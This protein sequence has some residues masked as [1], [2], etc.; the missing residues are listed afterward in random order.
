MANKKPL[1]DLEVEEEIARLKASPLVA[2]GKTE[3]RIR[4]RRRQYMYCLRQYEKKGAELAASG[5]TV[6]SL[7]AEEKEMR[8]ARQRAGAVK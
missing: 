4:I 2:L 6:E 3:E 8:R 7:L 5:V 1:T